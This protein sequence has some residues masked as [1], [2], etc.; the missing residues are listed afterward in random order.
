MDVGKKDVGAIG[1]PFLGSR[2]SPS[3]TSAAHVDISM[4]VW[5]YGRV[6]SSVAK[7]RHYT[8][9]WDRA[10]F[11]RPHGARNGGEP[12]SNGKMCLLLFF[13][14]SLSFPFFL[15]V[16]HKAAS[17][18][19][20]EASCGCRWCPATVVDSAEPSSGK[21][22]RRARVLVVIAWTNGSLH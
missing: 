9:L 13:S 8:I 2:H 15:F 10:T 22:C 4:N 1:N 7:P 3:C 17:F 19:R 5:I 6:P 18:T 21:S 16:M 11:D 12:W 20:V 14:L